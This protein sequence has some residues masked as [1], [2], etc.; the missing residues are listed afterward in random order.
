M[1]NTTDFSDDEYIKNA[2]LDWYLLL[3]ILDLW[4]LLGFYLV[5]EQSGT[6]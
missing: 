4:S 2:R 6:I 1:K 5:M 3:L